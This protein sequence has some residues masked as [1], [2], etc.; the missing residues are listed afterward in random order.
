ML[1]A[2]ILL[3]RCSTTTK[4]NNVQERL[5]DSHVLTTEFQ[6]MVLAVGSS[7]MAL[8]DPWRADMVAVSGEVTG[9]NALNFMHDR[10]KTSQEGR[11]ILKN[12]PE[13]K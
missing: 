2:R 1:C 7:M 6:K 9:K 8:N 5:Y 10:M 4:S 13:I 12:R 11:L 3:R